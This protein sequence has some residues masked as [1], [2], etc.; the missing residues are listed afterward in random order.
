MNNDILPHGSAPETLD[1]PHF[2][3]RFQAV[4]FRNWGL[5]PAERIAA[6]L[7]SDKQTIILH[8]EK[9]GLDTTD[10]N[11]DLWLKRGYVSIIR[12]N[13]QLL[14]YEGI[15]KLLD[16]T[17]E[18][19]LDTLQNEDFLYIKLGSLKPACPDLSCRPLDE[20]EE[21]QTAK[22]AETVRKYRPDYQTEKPF[23]FVN[24]ISAENYSKNNNDDGNLYI[25]YSYSALYGD[26]LAM[27]E[28]DPYPDN[29]LQALA[30]K[31]ING[32]WIP[33]ILYQ[34][35]YWEDAPEL[36]QNYKKR[37]DSLNALVAK[38]A[39]YGMKV[40][41]YLN[42]PRGLSITQYKNNAFMREKYLGAENISHNLYSMCTAKSAVLEYLANAVKSLFSSVPGLGGA[43]MITQS[44]N[45]TH[46][47]SRSLHDEPAPC[48]RCAEKNKS[49]II[50][51]ILTTIADAAHSVAPDAEIICWDW[52]WHEKWIPEIIEAL[53]EKTSIMAVSE[54]H[55]PVEF[56]GIKTE[57]VDYSLS[58]HGPG[59]K[60]LA[61]W[62]TAAKKGLK[63]FAKIQ[64]STT[65]EGSSVPYIPV[66]KL[67]DNHLQQLRAAGIKN[68]VTNWTLGGYPSFNMDLLKMSHDEMVIKNFGSKAAK[69]I[70]LALEHFSD[71]FRNFPFD[72]EV[73]YNSPHNIGPAN[74]LYST[75]T[76][77][78]ATMVGIPYDDLKSWVGPYT[79]EIYIDCLEKLCLKWQ[80]G[81]DCLKLAKADI[82]SEFEENY[83]DLLSVS[84]ACFCL[85]AD[86]ANQAKY[87]NELR[88]SSRKDETEKLLNDEINLAARLLKLARQ[89]SRLGF[90]ATN[91][92][93]YTH[94]ELLEKI[95]CCEWIKENIYK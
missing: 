76:N 29:L 57:V 48:P 54:S 94:N 13:W 22:I 16:W 67:L 11:C 90:E 50:S 77:Y 37:L 33:G 8:A 74:L 31:G 75:P 66:T 92:Y 73:V 68:Y 10:L 89:D 38:A 1:I 25:A 59:E 14:N 83:K 64:I 60:S 26:S 70:T 35:Y 41:L 56:G 80:Q 65:W 20:E 85:Y 78:R 21:K 84:E 15:M 71:A 6:A 72:V 93:A 12:T 44:E 62:Q 46:C 82:T 42:E 4:I 3:T 39:K 49:S 7:N 63:N 32:I 9:M 18:K 28:L 47:A 58:H 45:M 53:P 30:A 69:N 87:I 88:G 17:P 61:T 5:V 27:P 86:A 52:A 19:L 24:K 23:A 95:I 40:Y 79:P 81:L 2:P 55:V 43:F 51:E 34:L 36:S 91:H